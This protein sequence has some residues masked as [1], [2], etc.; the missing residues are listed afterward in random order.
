MH[1]KNYAP[2]KSKTTNNL[3]WGSVMH[4]ELYRIPIYLVPICCSSDAIAKARKIL[5]LFPWRTTGGYSHCQARSWL[6]NIF[7]QMQKWHPV[8]LFQNTEWHFVKLNYF[9]S[10]GYWRTAWC[11]SCWNN[12]SRWFPLQCRR[13]FPDRW[14]SSTG[15]FSFHDAECR[16]HWVIIG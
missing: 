1:N 15:T 11:N 12:I 7:S 9:N 2:R 10:T 4:Q 13:H 6:L 5:D 16:E 3:E 8:F 14:I